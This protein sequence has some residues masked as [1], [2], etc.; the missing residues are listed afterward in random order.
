MEDYL[1]YER[2]YYRDL[3]HLHP[4]EGQS[5]GLEAC[6]KQEVLRNE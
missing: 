5:T 2:G 3:Q 1:N 6:M 4:L